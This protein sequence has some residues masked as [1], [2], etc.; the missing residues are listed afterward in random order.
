MANAK[1]KIIDMTVTSASTWDT[2]LNSLIEAQEATGWVAQ[3]IGFDP[4]NVGGSTYLKAW[5][6]LVHQ[7]YLPGV[8][9]AHNTD[10]QNGGVDEISVAGLSGLLADG[11]TPLAHAASHQNGGADEISVADLSGLLADGQTP[12]AHIASHAYGGTDPVP[13]PT[14]GQ[15]VLSASDIKAISGTWTQSIAAGIPAVARTPNAATEVALFDIGAALRSRS[16]ALKG[17]VITSVELKYA[18]AGGAPGPA[19]DITCQLYR[20]AL[21]AH[22]VAATATENGGHYDEDH[23][24]TAE[25][26]LQEP[27]H[28]LTYTLDD[29]D[30]I[31][32]GEGCLLVIT[33]VDAGGFDITIRG[34]VVNYT[35]IDH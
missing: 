11:Q 31:A 30:P 8:V 24:I 18:Q 10:H 25:R 12:L 28:T 14:D 2:D 7:D 35:Y 32:N 5:A 29:M 15:V 13:A 34:L 21:N 22:G 33:I 27:D 3:K 1:S 16:T 26:Q 20:F 17:T 23:N 9:R 19:D 6:L 4:V